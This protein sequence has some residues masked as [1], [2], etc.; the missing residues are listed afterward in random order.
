ML[1]FPKLDKY[2]LL[3]KKVYSILKKEI[4]KGSFKPGNKILEFQIAQQNNSVKV[5]HVSF[6]GDHFSV[7]GPSVNA[8]NEYFGITAENVVQKAGQILA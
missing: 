3:S 4:I 5:K 1:N 7:I 6:P 8:L 2:N